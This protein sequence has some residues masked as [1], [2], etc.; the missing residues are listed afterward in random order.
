M[1]PNRKGTLKDHRCGFVALCGFASCAKPRKLFAFDQWIE[2]RLAVTHVPATWMDDHPLH[3][4]S[5]FC[6][7]LGAARLRLE[8]IP[9]SRST[10]ED[11]PILYQMGFQVA[12]HGP[13]AI[14]DTFEALQSK[15]GAPH[16]GPKAIFP[17]LYVRPRHPRSFGKETTCLPRPDDR[18]CTAPTPFFRHL[19]II[20][21]NAR[22]KLPGS[23]TP[24]VPS[25]L[26]RDVDPGNTDV[27]ASSLNFDH[28]APLAWVGVL[29]LTCGLKT[30]PTPSPRKRSNWFRHR[31]IDPKVIEARWNGVPGSE[32]TLPVFRQIF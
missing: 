17:R 24:A 14:R 25:G 9:Q 20:S 32:I 7:L 1:R 4:A 19:S 22:S 18:A 23:C 30:R 26:R 21:L 15:P 5:N 3:A 13:D 16:D 12:R 27:E 29:V 31:Q 6:H 10:S 11:H 28:P 2:A 8:D